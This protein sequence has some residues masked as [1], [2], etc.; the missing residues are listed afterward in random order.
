[1][2]NIILFDTLVFIRFLEGYSLVVAIAIRKLAVRNGDYLSNCV[3]DGVLFSK[4]N[5]VVICSYS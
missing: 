5:L 2:Y 4:F 1:M 3:I